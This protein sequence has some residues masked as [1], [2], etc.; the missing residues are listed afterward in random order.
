MKG[1][2]L[3]AG[4]GTRL[5]SITKHIPKP[6]IVVHGKPL[7]E[8]RIESLRQ[9]GIT[10][11][12]INVHYLGELIKNHLGDGERLGVKI[13]Y[14]T[15]EQLLDIAG[16]IYHALPLLGDAPFIVTSADILTD[17][18]LETLALP[19]NSLAHLVLVTN[20]NYHVQGDFGLMGNRIIAPQKS[21]SPFK[22]KRVPN[23]TFAN[24]AL[25]HPHFFSSCKAGQPAPILPLFQQHFWR[26]RLTGQLYEGQWHNINTAVELSAL[27]V[28]V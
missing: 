13:Q 24:I 6:L 27:S 14:S 23:Y 28:Q 21:P 1:M 4:R 20:P 22:G 8:H 11:I 9:A 5:Q 10:E 15:E 7:I 18:P 26:N 3:A 19:Q 25:Y 16:G 12:V 17:F 2:I